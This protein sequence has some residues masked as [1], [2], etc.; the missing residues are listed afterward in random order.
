M[1]IKRTGTHY[2]YIVECA[3]QTLYTGITTEVER[4]VEEHNSSSLGARYTRS[5]RPVELVYVRQFEDKASASTEEYR[6]KKLSRQEKMEMVSST[7]S[8]SNIS[9]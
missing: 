8:I 3:D 1:K 6:I 4:R 5:R 2:V 7:V 9:P